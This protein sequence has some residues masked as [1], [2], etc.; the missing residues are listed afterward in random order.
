MA[1]GKKELIFQAKDQD[2]DILTAVLRKP[3]ALEETEFRKSRFELD[4]RGKITKDTN[5]SLEA[6][7]ELFDIL[8]TDLKGVYFEEE[9][10]KQVKKPFSFAKPIP[11]SILKEA[12]CSSMK[13]IPTI[14][15]K[16]KAILI[17][18]EN[19]DDDVAKK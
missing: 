11:K 13:D 18:I 17:L 5:H 2:G 19:V 6:R 1:I 9:N 16:E 14:G 8:L 15:F 3:T 12:G 7:V 10:G 4:N